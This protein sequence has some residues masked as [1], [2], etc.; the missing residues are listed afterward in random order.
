VNTAW[1]ISP[2]H[3]IGYDVCQRCATNSSLTD[4]RVSSCEN[5][6][7]HPGSRES[8][9]APSAISAPPPSEPLPPP[10]PILDSQFFVLNPHP[11]SSACIGGSITRATTLLRNTPRDTPR[12]TRTGA[13]DMTGTGKSMRPQEAHPR[14]YVSRPPET[15]RHDREKQK[16]RNEPKPGRTLVIV[17]IATSY[18]QDKR[19]ADT[20]LGIRPPW[21]DQP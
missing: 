5:P 7:S 10:G 18:I 11:R 8:L 17:L 13:T 21:A 12:R 4:A 14:T 3:S 15:R 20:N 6:F 19:L 1:A 9:P 2:N 16:A